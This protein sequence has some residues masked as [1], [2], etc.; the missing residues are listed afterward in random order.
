MQ[1]ADGYK[2]ILVITDDFS[3]TT[4]LHLTRSADADTVVKVLLKHWISV[5][6]DPDLMHS[7]GG[8]HFDTQW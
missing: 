4:V 8:S 6:P 3:L 7:D 2:W 1:L 5:F